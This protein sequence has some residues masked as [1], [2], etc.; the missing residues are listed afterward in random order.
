MLN[1]QLVAT[2]HQ[3]QSLQDKNADLSN[4]NAMMVT[5]IMNLKSTVIN[6]EQ[7]L[8]SVVTFL[9]TEETK[10]RRET[11]TLFNQLSTTTSGDL[12]SGDLSSVAGDPRPSTIS[13]HPPS[14][15]MHASKLLSETNVDVLHSRALEQLN[16]PNARVNSPMVPT[17]T[18][19]TDMNSI[20]RSTTSSAPPSATSSGTLPFAE[21]EH[22]V[23]PIGDNNGID[24]MY[25]SHITNLTYSIPVKPM[26][27]PQ[28]PPTVPLTQP[29]KKGAVLDRWTR[30]PHILLVEDDMTCR[31]IGTKLLQNFCKCTVTT[32]VSRVFLVEILF[33]NGPSMTVQKHLTRFVTANP[34]I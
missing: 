1:T 19:S 8:Q 20:N 5:E 6:H 34:L 9:N 12:M 18:S 21:L 28:M 30:Q 3:I 10:R 33:T 14:P 2:Q 11:R 29:P 26:E 31:K 7:V 4:Q 27:P 16:H 32:A 13:D 22:L 24:P 15:L 23:Y 25:E 17:T